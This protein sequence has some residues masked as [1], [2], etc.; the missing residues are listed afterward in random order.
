[1]CF[2]KN[3]LLVNWSTGSILF[4]PL[5]LLYRLGS[6]GGRGFGRVLHLGVGAGSRDRA[7]CFAG[8]DTQG[9]RA[10]RHNSD[11]YSLYDLEKSFVIHNVDCLII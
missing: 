11:D 9:D 7:P 2:V 8:S 1:L 4:V 10:A 6:D 5:V 3:G